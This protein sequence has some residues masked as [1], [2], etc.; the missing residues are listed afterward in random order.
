M[1]LLVLLVFALPVGQQ[2]R[3]CNLHLWGQF[4]FRFLCPGDQQEANRQSTTHKKTHLMICQVE[5]DGCQTS[6]AQAKKANTASCAGLGP[7]T[8]LGFIG[9]GF[10]L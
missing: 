1:A 5:M 4:T 2:L 10:T 3:I 9:S 7:V 6:G 8:V